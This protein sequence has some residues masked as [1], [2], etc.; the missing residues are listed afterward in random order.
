MNMRYQLFDPF[1]IA[2]NVRQVYFVPYPS[3]RVDKR[4]WCTAIMTKPR[5]EIEK[6]GID[7][8]VDHPY[9]IDEMA[10]V[11][12]VITV[13]P[14]NRLCVG[15][16][17]AEEVPFEGDV[18]EDDEIHLEDGQEDDEDISDWDDN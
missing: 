2:H 12:D 8:D 3:T 16:D 11:A 14:L 13:E 18:D 4:G 9:Q 5:G 7:E 15:G 1:A 17:E 10:N 6:G